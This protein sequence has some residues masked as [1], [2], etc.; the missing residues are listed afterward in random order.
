M[1]SFSDSSVE[2]KFDLQTALESNLPDVDCWLSNNGPESEHGATAIAQAC[3]LGRLDLVNNLRMQGYSW[4][5]YACCAAAQYGHLNLLKYL[6][7]NGGPWDEKAVIYAARGGQ[8]DCLMYLHEKGCP[9]DKLV[10]LEFI[11]LNYMVFMRY[12]GK[13][14]WKDSDPLV[15]PA[16]GYVS[17][18][19]YALENGCPVHP[20]AFETFAYY[21]RLECLQVLHQHNVEWSTE[22]T[23]AAASM[24]HLSCLTYLHENGCP[25]DKTATVYSVFNGHV[26][27]LSYAI[28]HGC[29]HDEK[30]LVTAASTNNLAC[31][32]Y[33]L[34]E[35][36]MS[37]GDDGAV[38]RAAFLKGHL[39]CVQY[40]ASM[41][42]PLNA[43]TFELP[44]KGE[45]DYWR[46]TH[47]DA[48]F[49]AC[50]R[51]AVEHGWQHNAHLIEAISERSAE[52]ELCLPLC[53]AYAQQENWL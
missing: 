48:D 12:K 5:V 50:I 11:G 42:C 21:G 38:F 27:C 20:E 30:L 6:H 22:V 39:P 17:C 2:T 51:C 49:A 10:L 45:K 13:H 4:D 34:E 14:P 41:G 28:A 18:L 15:I 40:L 24:G 43:F 26:D 19:H 29:P 35:R 36:L 32:Q 47:K 31:L 53:Y 9:W 44:R 52:S 1:S 8:L 33:L 46:N 25:W 23:C 3:R 7:E 37:M 16:D